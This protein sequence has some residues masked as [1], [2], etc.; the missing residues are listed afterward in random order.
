VSCEGFLH[1]LDRVLAADKPV[2]LVL[3]GSNGA[4][5]S[6]F[7][8]LYLSRLGL[9]F[10]N[11]DRIAQALDPNDPLEIGYEAARVADIVRHE[12]VDQ[13]QSFCMETV[14]SDTAGS[15][16]Q[17]LREAQARGYTVVFLYFRLAN[18]ALS[19]ARV[20]QRVARGGHDVP[21]EKLAA[22]FVRTLKNAATALTFVDL[23]LVIDNS[24]AREPYRVVERWEA[25]I[26]KPEGNL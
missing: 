2:I 21:D 6:T 18:A 10:V 4:G 16:L 20:M 8:D 22:R 17:F 9:A 3:A 14:F 13:R 25:G 12:L 15:K 11:A 1:A 19:T 26:L 23:G 7:F 24:S 5:K